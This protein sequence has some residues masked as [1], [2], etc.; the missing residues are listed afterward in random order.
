[1][2][3][4]LVIGV[5]IAIFIVGTYKIYKKKKKQKDINNKKGD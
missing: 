2:F 4:G 5:S 1:M 3:T